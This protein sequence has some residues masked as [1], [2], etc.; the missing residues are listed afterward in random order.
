MQS[1]DNVLVSLKTAVQQRN[2]RLQIS[3]KNCFRKTRPIAYFSDDRKT[4]YI[5][6][7]WNQTDADTDAVENAA[8]SASLMKLAM[9]VPPH[10]IA[11]ETKVFL[12]RIRWS[13]WTCNEDCWLNYR[14]KWFAIIDT[15][16]LTNNCRRFWQFLLAR[17]C[18]VMSL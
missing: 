8:A 6:N 7:L 9:V 1:I 4:C 14:H 12:Y 2:S 15:C 13:M 3:S 17:L 11:S 18:V 10:L 5:F 16:S